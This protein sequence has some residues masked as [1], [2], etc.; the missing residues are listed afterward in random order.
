MKS[1]GGSNE[2]PCS[3]CF[4]RIVGL[5]PKLRKSPINPVF[6]MGVEVAWGE[7]DFLKKVSLSPYI[8]IS[9]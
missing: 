9:D 8:F 3:F 1:Q 4:K 2:P 7:G 5:C 6:L